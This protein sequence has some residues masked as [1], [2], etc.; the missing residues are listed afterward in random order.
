[1]TLSTSSVSRSSGF[2]RLMSTV[3]CPLTRSAIRGPNVG[4]DTDDTVSEP[5]RRKPS[6]LASRVRVLIL[7]VPRPLKNDRSGSKLRS[8]P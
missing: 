3:F 1:M 6:V 8:T 2:G 7:S 4:D 5:A